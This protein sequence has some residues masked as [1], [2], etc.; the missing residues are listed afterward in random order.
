M[1]VHCK[2][3]GEAGDIG[4]NLS[5]SMDPAIG[6]CLEGLCLLKQEFRI[7]GGILGEEVMRGQLHKLLLF[8]RHVIIIMEDQEFEEKLNQALLTIGSDV[9]SEDFPETPD[10]NKLEYGCF[11]DDFAEETEEPAMKRRISGPSRLQIEDGA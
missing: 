6:L 4:E 9:S 7:G 8:L 3:K 11:A 10:L 2:R 5:G 1:S